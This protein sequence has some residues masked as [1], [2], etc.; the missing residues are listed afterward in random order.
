MSATGRERRGGAKATRSN[1]IK[2]RR[3]F[4]CRFVQKNGMCNRLPHTKRRPVRIAPCVRGIPE[5]EFGE[6]GTKDR[7][8]FL[9][10]K[11]SRPTQGQPFNSFE[12]K[13]SLGRDE[14]SNR[15]LETQMLQTFKFQVNESWY[16]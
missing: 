2:C 4:L 5:Q 12:K 13:T 14:L 15:S 1:L 7:L 8:F 16:F 11:S 6:T 3:Q 9:F 10:K